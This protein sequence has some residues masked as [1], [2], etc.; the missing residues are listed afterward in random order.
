[1]RSRRPSV[2]AFCIWLRV[3][4]SPYLD[5]FAIPDQRNGR[6]P[7]AVPATQRAAALAPARDRGTARCRGTR[8]RP[9]DR[10]DKVARRGSAAHCLVSGGESLGHVG[11]RGRHPCP[12][13][14]LPGRSA[15]PAPRSTINC[16]LPSAIASARISHRPGV[17]H[18]QSRDVGWRRNLPSQFNRS[19]RF[20]TQDR[21]LC[22]T[23]SVIGP[24]RWVL[25]RKSVV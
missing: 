12:S 5:C 19:P 15:A 9:P 24:A 2:F 21:A 17:G 10:R 22:C 20:A 6:R 4:F 18:S 3:A 1:M 11:R 8:H 23:W 14:R 25:D 16:G 7:L 13:R